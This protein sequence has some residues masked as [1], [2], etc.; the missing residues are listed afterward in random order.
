MGF[1][2]PALS[3]SPGAGGARP[4]GL[5]DGG[6]AAFNL[7][8]RHRDA[9]AIAIGLLPPLNLRWADVD[10]NP[11]AKFDPRR[12]G[13]R[14][15]FDDSQEIIAN[16]HNIVKIRMGHVVRPIF[17]DGDEALMNIAENNPIEMINKTR[18]QNGELSMFVGYAGRDEFN[19]D[20]QVESFLYYARFRGLNVAVAYEPDGHH[21]LKTAMKFVP[22]VIRW[23][24]PQIAPYAPIRYPAGTCPP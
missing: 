13:W 6:F 9:F 2:V 12:W 19:I 14:S 7:G 10:G 20:A 21:D 16:F 1:C 15:G 23:L 8:M 11:R 3:D 17:G 24:G 18:L 4:G 5:V 22:S